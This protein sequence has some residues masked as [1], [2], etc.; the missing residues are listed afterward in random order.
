M[1]NRTLLGAMLLLTGALCIAVAVIAAAWLDTSYAHESTALN[2]AQLQA[3]L[4]GKT[5]NDWAHHV[6]I[7]SPAV[8]WAAFAIGGWLI[9][10]GLVIGLRSLRQGE[11][12]MT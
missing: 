5:V 12:R 7:V 8:I 2:Q 1:G 6:S 10:V 11:F 9:L 4:Q 3:A